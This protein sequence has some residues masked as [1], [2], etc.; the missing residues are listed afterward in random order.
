MA[1]LGKWI[2]LRIPFGGTAL[3][4][5]LADAPTG[6]WSPAETIYTVPSPWVNKTAGAHAY[7]PKHHRE[8]SGP[9]EMV[10]TYMSNDPDPVIRREPRLYVPQVLRVRWS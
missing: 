6:P 3:Q 2:V 9:N 10:I 8:L 5:R 4:I 1:A 7:S